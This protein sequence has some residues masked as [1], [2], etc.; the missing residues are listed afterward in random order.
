MVLEGRAMEVRTAVEAVWRGS[1]F[2]QHLGSAVAR[3]RA[4]R[5]C[6]DLDLVG[7]YSRLG[8]RGGDRLS[9]IQSSPITVQLLDCAVS[10]PGIADDANFA[11]VLL[12]NRQD[13]FERLPIL[14]GQGGRIG[15]ELD[16]GNGSPSSRGR[17]CAFAGIARSGAGRGWRRRQFWCSRRRL[18]AGGTIRLRQGHWGERPSGGEPA[19]Q[20][21]GS[22]RN[23]RGGRQ[24]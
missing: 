10:G 15:A 2:E 14:V 3:V 22:R 17:L 9:A 12:I 23:S 24:L 18:V 1:V 21:R 4:L 8:Q 13:R 20:R 16:L 5:R 6:L 19:R 7:R 11:G